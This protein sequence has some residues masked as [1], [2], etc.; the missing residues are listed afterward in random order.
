M[1][2]KQIPIQ[3]IS[4]VRPWF[5]L[6]LALC[7]FCTT[8]APASAQGLSPSFG[9]SVATVRLIASVD[10]T[11]GQFHV[12][13]AIVMK[14]GSHTYWKDPGD[15]GVPPV[16][17]FNGSRNVSAAQVL[18][19]APSRIKEEGLEAYGYTDRV[20]FPVLVKPADGT[21]PASLHVDIAYAVCDRICVPATAKADLPLPAPDAAQDT[22]AV[23]AAFAEVPVPL[24][25]DHQGDL[26]VAAV[27]GGAKP[28][29]SVIWSGA[30]TP[31]GCVRRSAGR[32]RVR[33][34]Q[35]RDGG[36]LDPRRGTGRGRARPARRPR[37]LDLGG[38]SPQLRDDAHPRSIEARVRDGAINLASPR[39][40]RWTFSGKIRSNI[41]IHGLRTIR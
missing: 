12:A 13:V 33:D 26:T 25:A 23:A 20:T 16:F 11:G 38:T 35:G 5:P 19:P 24:P 31:R 39:K 1:M 6:C 34:P 40:R 8:P 28:T 32:L 27:S 3:V 36:P 22:A 14:P 18:F 37:H 7:A 10:R 30:T 21:A 4:V 29:W 2:V 9:E 15:A 17:A 41:G